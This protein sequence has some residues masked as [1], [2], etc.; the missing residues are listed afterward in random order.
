MTILPLGSC[1]CLFMSNVTLL[2]LFGVNVELSLLQSVSFYI[3]LMCG[4]WSTGH[5][6]SQKMIRLSN[7]DRARAIGMVQS[8]ASCHDVA[9]TFGVN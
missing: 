1:T 6:F 3:D 9:W 4:P 7:L 8:G 5:V 2:L